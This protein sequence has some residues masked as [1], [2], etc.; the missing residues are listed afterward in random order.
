MLALGQGVDA[1][2][3][4]GDVRLTMGGEPTFVATEDRD[5]P[6][7]NT[8]ALGRTKRGFATELVHRLRTEYGQGGFLHFGQGKW[9]PGEPLPRWALSI[10]WRTDGQPVWHKPELFADE[11]QPQRYTA[12][13]AERFMTTLARTLGVSSTRITAMPKGSS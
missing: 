1:R 6:E 13:D 2:L 8:D 9:Y 10:Y 7:W 12:Q 11:R 5:A 4:A 3:E